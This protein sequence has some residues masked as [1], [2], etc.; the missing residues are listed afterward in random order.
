MYAFSSQSSS[1]L[2]KGDDLSSL[3]G[4][5][6]GSSNTWDNA[7]QSFAV[8]APIGYATP[9]YILTP[10][11]MVP[12]FSLI[13]FT[14]WLIL[15]LI[16]PIVIPRLQEASFTLMTSLNQHT[17]FPTILA[18]HQTPLRPTVPPYLAFR[19]SSQATP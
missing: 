1:L 16:W 3:T 7:I 11:D 18:G 19:F 13:N 2:V 8:I 9:F 12:P 4:Y 6:R 17:A 14:M 10:A 5:S 15:Q